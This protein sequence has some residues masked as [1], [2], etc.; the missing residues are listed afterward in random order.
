MAVSASEL[1]DLVLDPDGEWASKR[2]C[3]LQAA[4]RTYGPDERERLAAALADHPDPLVR[5]I[6]AVPFAAWSRDEE[7]LRLTHDASASV[8]KLAV[9]RLGQ[10]PPDPVLAIAAWDYFRD[11]AGT[12]AS[13]AVRT[14]V[15]HSP[16]RGEAAPGRAGPGRPSGERPDEGDLVSRPP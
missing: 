11:A 9:Y 13:E 14:Y 16:G 12:T 10:L 7:L 3:L 2:R 6:A 15:A 8:R 5:E 4:W 1:L